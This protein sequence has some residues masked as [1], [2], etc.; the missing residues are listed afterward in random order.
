MDE[1]SLIS[2]FKFPNRLNV[3]YFELDGLSSLHK[4]RP[5]VCSPTKVIDELVIV[6]N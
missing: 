3:G 2:V 1:A 4:Y 6:E 5:I